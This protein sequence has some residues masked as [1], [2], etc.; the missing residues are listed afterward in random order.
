MKENQLGRRITKVVIWVA[1]GI[2]GMSIQWQEDN[3][4]HPRIGYSGKIIF[5]GRGYRNDFFLLK[6]ANK[7]TVTTKVAF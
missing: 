5:Q 1:K 3:K 7:K 4:V 6:Q 2:R